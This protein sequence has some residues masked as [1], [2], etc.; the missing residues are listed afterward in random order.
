M[1][2]CARLSGAVSTLVVL[3]ACGSD[4]TV[5]FVGTDLTPATEPANDFS[6]FVISLE[7]IQ[8]AGGS[9]GLGGNLGGHG[10]YGAFYCFAP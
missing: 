8:A 5:P 4:E 2:R 1:Q 6:F 7:A 10:G 9:E 3:P